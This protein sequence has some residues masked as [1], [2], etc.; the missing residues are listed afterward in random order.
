MKKMLV[1]F[2]NE[3]FFEEMLIDMDKFKLEKEFDDEMF[4]WYNGLFISIKKTII[5][6]NKIIT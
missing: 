5:N 6:T 3:S 4:G 2:P 1:R